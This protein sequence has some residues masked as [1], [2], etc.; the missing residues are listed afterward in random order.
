MSVVDKYSLLNRDKLAK[1]IQIQLFR[2]E[3]KKISEVFSAFLNRN[4]NFEHS[5]KRDG[6]DR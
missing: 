1:T 3:K 5:E 6:P 4:L 2:K